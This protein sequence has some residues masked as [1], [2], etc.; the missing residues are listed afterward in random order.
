MAGGEKLRKSKARISVKAHAEDSCFFCTFDPAFMTD[1]L[2]KSSR[3]QSSPLAR[4]AY[5]SGFAFALLA[6]VAGLAGIVGVLPDLRMLAQPVKDWPP[7]PLLAAISLT[8]AGFAAL[9]VPAAALPRRLRRGRRGLRRRGRI[10][11]IARH[12]PAG[13][14]LLHAAR[15]RAADPRGDGAIR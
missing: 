13:G 10:A 11:R 12:Q 7:V 4:V 15:V 6:A 3:D 9:A 5:Q 1:Q 8:A 14:L 2:S